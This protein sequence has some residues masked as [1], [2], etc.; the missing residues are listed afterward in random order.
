M[1]GGWLFNPH[2]PPFQ[3]HSRT[4]QDA[5]GKVESFAETLRGRVLRW[6][7]ERA[8]HGATDE[9]GIDTLLIPA[10]TYRP[11]RVELVAM[12]LVKDSGQTRPTKTNRQ[13]TVWVVASSTTNVRAEHEHSPC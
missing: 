7:Q 8:E 5:A 9:E 4:S 1:A 6:L 11:R 3:R 10:S 12:G 13:A 2:N